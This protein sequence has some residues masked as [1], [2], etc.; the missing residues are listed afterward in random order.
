MVAA[1][2]ILCVVNGFTPV[3][4]TTTF[5]LP[6][7][8]GPSSQLVAG[9]LS[10]KAGAFVSCMTPARILMPRLYSNERTVIPVIPVIVEVDPGLLTVRRTVQ[11]LWQFGCRMWSR[12][13]VSSNTDECW[14]WTGATTTMGYGV[15]RWDL[16]GNRDMVY[17]HQIAYLWVFGPTLPGLMVRHTCYIPHCCN[18]NHFKLQT[19]R[20]MYLDMRADGRL[21]SVRG[22]KSGRAKLN[23]K[24]VLIIR[25]SPGVQ[26]ALAEK[27]GVSEETI[28]AAKS[29]KSWKHI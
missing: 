16:T 28:W 6:D 19:A 4:T 22:E 7:L 29:G 14:K 18:P 15:A 27:F 13:R 8:I 26:R 17:I 21:Q 12:I 20:E 2:L 11:T 9:K 3:Q 10:G 24:K 23:N 25:N 5:P 1:L